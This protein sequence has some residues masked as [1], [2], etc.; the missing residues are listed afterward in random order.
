LIIALDIG[1]S[2]EI[3]VLSLMFSQALFMSSLSFLFYKAAN[4]FGVLP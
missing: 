3:L 1:G 2:N 4:L